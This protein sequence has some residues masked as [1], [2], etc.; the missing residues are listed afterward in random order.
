VGGKHGYGEAA[1]WLA[2]VSGFVLSGNGKSLYLTGDTIWCEEVKEN[3]AKFKPDVTIVFGGAAQFADGSPITMTVE[4]IYELCKLAPQTKVVAV[5]MDAI[6]HCIFTR[7]QLRQCLKNTHLENQVSVPENGE[8][9][10]F[11]LD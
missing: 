9:L 6:N 8:K 10:N 3:L 11:V 5:H 4:G 7:E 2:P 1:K